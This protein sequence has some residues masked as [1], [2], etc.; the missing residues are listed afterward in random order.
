MADYDAKLLREKLE[1]L[2]GDRPRQPGRAA[3]RL[4]DLS[5]LM[6]LPTRLQAE[7]AAGSVPTKAEFDRLVDDINTLHRRLVAFIET[8]QKRLL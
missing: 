3:L 5:G 4:E 1:A 6:E 8:V 2:N 7:K